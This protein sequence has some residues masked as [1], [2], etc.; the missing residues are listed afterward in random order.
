MSPAFQYS[1]QVFIDFHGHSRQKN[2][3]LYGCSP[4]ETWRCSAP[5]ASPTGSDN[6]GKIR[7]ELSFSRNGNL[8]WLEACR[9][10]GAWL[11]ESASSSTTSLAT[12][13][14]EIDS[15][16]YLIK[17]IWDG[18][19]SM[20]DFDLVPSISS[21]ADLLLTRDEGAL[22]IQPASLTNNETMSRQTRVD[23]QNPAWRGDLGLPEDDESC[24][25]LE[26]L[27]SLFSPAF[28][29]STCGYS[30][31]RVKE[32][33][34]RVV[35]WREFHVLRSFTMEA[36]Y[37]GVDQNCWPMSRPKDSA[38]TD[39]GHQLNTQHLESIGAAL[40]N[41]L[42]LL[43]QFDRRRLLKKADELTSFMLA[44]MLQLHD[45]QNNSLSAQFA[46][47]NSSP[48]QALPPLSPPLG[49]SSPSSYDKL[50]LREQVKKNPDLAPDPSFL[51]STLVSESSSLLSLTSDQT[52]HGT[53]IL[54]NLSSNTPQ[55]GDTL[56]SST[57]IVRPPSTSS[58]SSVFSSSS[59]SSSSS[60][61]SSI[62]SAKPSYSLSLESVL[63]LDP[64]ATDHSTSLGTRLSAVRSNSDSNFSSVLK[65]RVGS[66][67]R[68]NSLLGIYQPGVTSSQ[69]DR[70]L[71]LLRRRLILQGKGRSRD[72]P[73]E[74]LQF[75]QKLNLK[76]DQLHQHQEQCQ[77]HS[78]QKLASLRRTS[79]CLR[80]LQTLV[81]VP[82][83]TNCTAVERLKRST[84][85]KCVNKSKL[86]SHCKKWHLRNHSDKLD[87][88]A[89]VQGLT[90]EERKVDQYIVRSARHE[91]R[92]LSSLDAGGIFE[93][94][95]V[96]GS[97]IRRR[98]T[99]RNP[100]LGRRRSAVSTK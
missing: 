61:R 67:D 2:V 100:K 35:V 7:R 77:S 8:D 97:K 46:P 42:L 54:R 66:K 92:L 47:S 33:T 91:V 41:A 73:D 1:S 44:N 13:T 99:I 93:S 70:P 34:A 86:V 3:F 84:P 50:P 43:P 68:R 11:I 24:R 85:R 31:S 94:E 88:P 17:T 18:L 9:Q 81:S 55:A 60:S 20:I 12:F 62:S 19:I 36:S 64:P 45:S 4:R 56:L 29:R 14:R 75:H 48:S 71:E 87:S 74:Y 6:G 23:T 16:S 5:I 15:C 95:E 96:K 25:E 28:S 98:K 38:S 65:T 49:F 72:R 37:C 89:A 32:S 80:K 10:L 57:K 21:V 83:T 40:C 63:Q 78:K 82:A 30:V 79:G 39:K 51:I 53:R 76:D 90:A 69:Y 58:L 26:R 27:M 52:K 59:S 22:S